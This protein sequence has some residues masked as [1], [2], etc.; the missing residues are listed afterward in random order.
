MTP[1]IEIEPSELRVTFVRSSGPGGQNVNKVSTRA[2]V[3]FNVDESRSLTER[4][5]KLIRRNL[6]GRISHTG[7]LRVS[8]QRHRT[9]LA[10]REEAVARLIDL[11]S[12]AATPP[13]PRKRTR[14]PAQA[15][16]ARLADKRHRSRVKEL[17]S[18]A[19]R[20]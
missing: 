11:L 2:V 9:Q 3:S 7:L 13:R 19:G 20:E 8:C 12:I 10:N 4:Q 17:R 14:V 15:K 18:R 16:A 6:T 1:P 5:R